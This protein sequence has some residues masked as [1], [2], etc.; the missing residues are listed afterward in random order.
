VGQGFRAELPL[1]ASA[2]KTETPA[3]SDPRDY[4]PFILPGFGMITVSMT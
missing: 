4:M 1:G 3:P 2:G